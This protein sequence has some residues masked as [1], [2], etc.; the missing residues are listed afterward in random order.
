MNWLN[1]KRLLAFL[2]A[3]MILL[4]TQEDGSLDSVT[5]E[6]FA[7]N[8][9][10][11]LST[12]TRSDISEPEIH[13]IDDSATLLRSRCDYLDLIVEVNLGTA[14]ENSFI[15]LFYHFKDDDANRFLLSELL[16]NLPPPIV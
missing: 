8:D 15:G 13:S 7:N 4:P 14:I 12:N 10:S 11:T 5:F 2:L 6:L 9:Y 1:G 16:L 3:S